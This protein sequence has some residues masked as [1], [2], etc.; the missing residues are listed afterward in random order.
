[1][2][3]LL[4]ELSIPSRCRRWQVDPDAGASCRK[5]RSPSSERSLIVVEVMIL[6]ALEDA[7]DHHRILLDHKGHAS[8]PL[9]PDDAQ[10]RP[11]VSAHGATL[12][13]GFKTP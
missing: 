3:L 2:A 10:A 5:C 11:V 13:K 7:E 6:A 4:V 1:M 8:S 12:G 9:D